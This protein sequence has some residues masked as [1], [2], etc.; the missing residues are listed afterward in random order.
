VSIPFPIERRGGMKRIVILICLIG[1]VQGSEVASASAFPWLR[2]RPKPVLLED[3]HSTEPAPVQNRVA[4]HGTPAY[5]GTGRLYFPD[6]YDRLAQPAQTRKP[7]VSEAV[8]HGWR[9]NAAAPQ[10]KK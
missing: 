5:P 1:M 2:T 9:G 3:Q 7:R 10:V 6:A 4:W 8:V